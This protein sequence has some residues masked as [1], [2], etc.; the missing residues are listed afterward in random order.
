VRQVSLCRRRCR[1]VVRV[2]RRCLARCGG[3]L[4]RAR[5]LVLLGDRHADLL[6]LDLPAVGVR[7]SV[8]AQPAAGEHAARLRRVL[9]S[10]DR[11]RAQ[12]AG[13]EPHRRDRDRHDHDRGQR[14]R[15]LEHRHGVREAGVGVGLRHPRR[16]VAELHPQHAAGAA[17]P[18]LLEDQ[19]PLALGARRRARVSAALHGRRLQ[20]RDV[21]RQRRHDDAQPDCR[22]AQQHDRGPGGGV[23]VHV[24]EPDDRLHRPRDLLEQRV[25]QRA[26]QSGRGELPP[27][28]D[29]PEL[30]VPAARAAGRRL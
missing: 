20:C 7:V 14:R 21:L 17:Q 29:R 1:R 25:D 15:V 24:Q 13:R 26:V 11:Q 16:L 5:R 4:R 30:R 10:E 23:R 22:P 28:P 2:R 19:E 3:A 8:P 6:R 27:Q 12:H 18:G 9:G